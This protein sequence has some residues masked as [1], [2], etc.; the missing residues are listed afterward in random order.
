MCPSQTPIKNRRH[1]RRHRCRHHRSS[2]GRKIGAV[3]PALGEKQRLHPL[4][5]SGAAERT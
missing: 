2:R 3:N 5:N 4:P 1:R